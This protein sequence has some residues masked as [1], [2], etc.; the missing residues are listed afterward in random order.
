MTLKM[1][2]KLWFVARHLLL[3]LQS[4]L[5]FVL[6]YMINLVESCLNKK[7]LQ[8]RLPNKQV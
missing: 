2:R 4:I 8:E 3:R 5:D 7:K 1:E 6:R